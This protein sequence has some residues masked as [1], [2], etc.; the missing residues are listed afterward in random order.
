MVAEISTWYGLVAK[1]TLK[2][3]VCYRVTL[4]EAASML[5]RSELPSVG[6]VGEFEPPDSVIDVWSSSSW[7]KSSSIGNLPVPVTSAEIV[8][9]WYNTDF[10]IMI[11]GFESRC[12]QSFF[13]L[14]PYPL[15]IQKSL[16]DIIQVPLGQSLLI[17]E[18]LIKVFLALLPW[19]WQ[20]WWAHI[21]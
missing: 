19:T 2:R 9:Q 20:T 7:T 21:R 11:G 15:L 3:W 8:A 12:V 16:I 18:K 10:M 6:L 14:I 17:I 1:K 13:F 4:S 5:P